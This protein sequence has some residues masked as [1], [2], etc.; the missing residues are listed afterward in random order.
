MARRQGTPAGFDGQSFESDEEVGSF[1][2]ALA[3]AN[4]QVSS[5]KGALRWVS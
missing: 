2:E 3:G 1:Y 5:L 4:H